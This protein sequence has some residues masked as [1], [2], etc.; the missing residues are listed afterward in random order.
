M[1]LTNWFKDLKKS[2]ICKLFVGVFLLLPLFSFASEIRWHSF[3]EGISLA[4]KQNKLIL[5]DIYAKWCHWCNVIENTTYRDEKVIQ[6]I[7]KYYIPVRVDAEK[8]P[9]INKNYNQGGLPSTVILTPDRKIIFGAIY[10]SP[11]KMAEVLEYFATL[12]PE[13]LETLKK[14]VEKRR[15]FRERLL[16]RL[17]KQKQ[18]NP[19]FLRKIFRYITIRYDYQYGG[20]KGAPK[21][22]RT[23]VVYFLLDYWLVFG[24]DKAK[25]L[26]KKTLDAYAYMIDKEEGGIYRYSVNEYWTEFHYE[27]LLK[28]QANLSILYYSGYS[29]F[30]EKKYLKFANLL[31]NFAINRLYS[32]EKGLFYNSQG[33]DIVDENGTLLMSGEEYFIKSKEEREKIVKKLGYAP[34]IEKAFY[35]STNLLAVSALVYGYAFN[36]NPEYLKL[37]KKVFKNLEKTY[38]TEKGV[39]YSQEIDSYYLSSQVYYLQALLDLYQ[40]TGD[41]N[42][43]YKAK[44]F[45]N[46]LDTHFYNEKLGIY[47]DLQDTGLNIKNISFIDDIF[48]LN[49]KL[50]VFFYKMAL[51]LENEKIFE[52][53]EKLAKKLPTK[54]N[55]ETGIAYFTVLIKPLSSR[56]I[57]EK[58][59]DSIKAKAFR[60]FPFFHYSQPITDKTFAKKLDYP[61]STNL[62]I[63]I[64]N[65]DMCFKKLSNVDNLEPTI[66]EIYR[67]I[68][69]RIKSK[70]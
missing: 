45:L 36:Q 68:G 17:L 52:K 4:K 33:A 10:L 5:M 67:Q 66:V 60:T 54:A 25:I 14:K 34:N 47:T 28:D 49:A 7:N 6:L 58:V 26:A 51:F 30:K 42:Y 61:F 11:E 27:K 24:D 12:P 8:R 57:G 3:E 44:K 39:K 62:Q 48:S 37:A 41:L 40:I 31:L 59:S 38:L 64:C 50:A 13:R 23:D 70:N 46:I 18:L 19:A 55:I 2:T 22:P 69:E 21:F 43:L 63:Y 29:V 16:V 56:V 20:L 15:S 32:P 1:S 65:T 9:D 35:S 53:A